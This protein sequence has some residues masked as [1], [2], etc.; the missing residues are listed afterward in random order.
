[1]LPGGGFYNGWLSVADTPNTCADPNA[2]AP[3]LHVELTDGA[4]RVLGYQS[5]VV[6]RASVEPLPAD[7]ALRTKRARLAS[8]FSPSVL[9]HR[10]VLDLGANAGFFA[11]WAAHAGA[12]SVTAVDLDPD[13]VA[14]AERVRTHLG[15]DR[16]RIVRQNVEDWHEPA[17][18]VLGLAL[19]HWIYSCT[20]RF[21]SLDAAIARLASLTRYVLVLEWVAPDDTAIE[22]FGHLD[23]GGGAREGPY[24][25]DAFEAALRRH[26]PRVEAL[27]PV[28]ETRWLVAA[29][30]LP[31]DVDLSGPLPFLFDKRAVIY[32]RRLATYE[33]VDYWTR[34]Y[35]DGQAIHKQATLDLAAREARILQRLA[36]DPHFP[37]VVSTEANGPYSVLT[38]E[39]VAGIPF[40]EAAAALSDSPEAAQDLV[41]QC[42]T[43]L[44]T[45]HRHGIAHRDINPSNLII[46]DG[47]PV[48]LD[49][50]WAS[51]PGEPIFTPPGLNLYHLPPDGSSSDVFA[52]GRTLAPLFDTAGP[53]LAP[54]VAVM[55]SPDASQRVDDPSALKE[56][57]DICTRS[58]AP[59]ASPSVSL[60]TAR[61]LAEQVQRRDA[62]LAWLR[63]RLEGATR[64]SADQAARL[65]EVTRRLADAEAAALDA[66]AAADRLQRDLTAR[67]EAL[68]VL[69]AQV[70]EQDRAVRWL[71]GELDA[72]TARFDETRRA[73]ER[74]ADAEALAAALKRQVEQARADLHRRGARVARERRHVRRLEAALAATRHEL[75]A[76]T[77]ARTELAAITGSRSWR[78]LSAYRRARGAV[79]SAAVWAW[80]TAV[81]VPVRRKLFEWRRHGRTE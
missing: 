9:A 38:L 33:D 51:T 60:R 24:S 77:D 10:D 17:D 65:D 57:L 54:I 37:Q 72:R 22:R 70:T 40:S 29:Y 11:F 81:P 68:G 79:R 27:G 26:F 44:E 80:R 74:L 50:G 5:F 34:V 12:D 76:V 46:R 73:G 18:V 32:S 64:R 8:I 52:M 48:L 47:C 36:S 4:A 16:V 2:F 66:R 59:T 53:A 25:R 7:A 20:A 15:L 1:M 30:T 3:P 55:T 13:Y 39:R 19:I 23:W 75:R 61:A 63:E 78:A 31:R 28:S 43:I 6:T 49:F 62:H 14:A 56:L 71:R 41:G 67:Q 69:S 35:D 42:L 21:G 45:L 58:A